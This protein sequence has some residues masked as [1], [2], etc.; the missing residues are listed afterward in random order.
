[1]RFFLVYEICNKKLKQ[2]APKVVFTLG[3]YYFRS[4]LLYLQGRQKHYEFQKWNERVFLSFLKDTGRLTYVN[5]RE[6]IPKR[7][8]QGKGN[9]HA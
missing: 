4:P 3:E 8:K 1:M 5:D 2:G 9:I 7:A 6:G